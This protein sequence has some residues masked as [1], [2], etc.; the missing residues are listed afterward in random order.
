MRGF[1]PCCKF[2]PPEEYWY[3]TGLNSH[4]WNWQPSK[5]RVGI[6]QNS[7]NI[8]KRCH[9]QLHYELE[10]TTLILFFKKILLILLAVRILVTH[11]D[12]FLNSSWHFFYEKFHAACIKWKFQDRKCSPDIF[13]LFKKIVWLKDPSSSSQLTSQQSSHRGYVLLQ[14]RAWG[15]LQYLYCICNSICAVFVIVFVLCYVLPQACAW[16]LQEEVSKSQLVKC[17]P[18]KIQEYFLNPEKK[19][20]IWIFSFDPIHLFPMDVKS[21]WKKFVS[22]VSMCYRNEMIGPT[23]IRRSTSKLADLPPIMWNVLKW[24]ECRISGNDQLMCV[25]A[26]WLWQDPANKVAIWS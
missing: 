1:F 17:Q 6:Q 24:Q 12:R 19:K 10:H 9:G 7:I 15:S 2:S 5:G 8:E 25:G 4:I 26:A 13:D 11:P 22:C 3:W 21:S 14:L 16:R 23:F 20:K 18:V